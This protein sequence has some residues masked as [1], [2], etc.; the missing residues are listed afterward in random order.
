MDG[1]TGPRDIYGNPV[2]IF[3][4]SANCTLDICPIEYSVYEY[5]PTLSANYA[6]IAI[7]GVALLVHAYL[8]F[9]WKSWWYMGCMVVGCAVEMAGYGGRI[10]L[11]DNPFNFG[12]FLTQI[13]CIT[14]APVF[15]CAGIYVTIAKAVVYFDQS[16]SRIHPK[17]YYWI[18]IVCDVVSLTLQGSGGALSSVSDGSSSIGVDLALAGLGFQ[19]AT[20]FFFCVLFCDYLFRYS[21]QTRA[22]GKTIG[23]R[24][25]VF[26]SFL[27]LAIALI[28][29]RCAFR[30]KELEDGYEGE[31][32]HDETLFIALE[33]VLVVLAVFALCLGHPGVVFG[34]P[35]SE[36][37]VAKSEY[38][39]GY[40]GRLESQH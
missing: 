17:L 39:S 20:L 28:L 10:M 5:Q 21:R 35:E 31:L 9:R 4:P 36:S 13:V 32:I 26:F 27:S 23:G 11:H 25:K 24:V 19:V 38:E 34:R 12:A 29:A 15:Y 22:E 14:T 30:V 37:G 1:Y 18:F 8:G 3:G 7:F 6:F 16:I 40:S 33:G 2:E